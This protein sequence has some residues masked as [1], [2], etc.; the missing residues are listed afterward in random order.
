MDRW[1]RALVRTVLLGLVF[2]LLV[3]IPAS[4]GPARPGPRS[5]PGEVIVALE[6][7]V[8]ASQA[9]DLYRD[10]DVEKLESLDSDPGD[11]DLEESL[12][13]V[14]ATETDALIRELEGDARVEYAEPNY[15]LTAD[16]APGDPEFGRLWGMNNTGQTGGTPDADID[17][18]EAWDVTTGSPSVIVGVIDTGI[19]YN[20][21]DLAA[22]V[23][24]NPGE[25][26][27][28]HMDNDGNGYVDDVHGINAITGSGDPMDDHGHGT[29]VT[30]TIGAVGGNGKGVA[31]VNWT[32]RIAACKFLNA[33]ATGTTADAIECFK[34]FNRLKKVAGQNIVVTSNSW[35]GASFSQ[36]LMD[37]MAGLDQPGMSPILHVAA[38]GNS[39]R[40][41]DATPHYPDGYNLPN[42]VSVAATDP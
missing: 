10:Y 27:G 40:S 35:G 39:A 2:S 1:R 41:N 38:A 11:R 31:G 28:D 6:P 29:H 30:G 18:P 17:A 21:V 9:A 5:V 7:G 19:D 25:V 22:N 26:P 8:T 33:Q 15:I 3:S 12:V 32:V 42:I 20:H 36:A 16:V 37:A 4:A 14:P 13:D 23:W 34:Y 24:T